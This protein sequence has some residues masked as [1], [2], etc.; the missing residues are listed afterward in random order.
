M[1]TLE[2]NGLIEMFR[3]NPGLA[4]HFLALLFHVDVPAHATARVADSALDQLIPIEFRA[5]LVLELRDAEGKL[6]LAIVLESQRD[7]APR[8]KFSWPVYITVARAERECD[9]VVL[10]IA[11]DAEIAAWAAQTIDLGLGRGTVE[12]FVL[13]PATV[14]VVTDRAVA[15]REIELAILLAMAH[16]NGPKGLRVVQVVFQALAPRPRAQGGGLSDHL[17]PVARACAR[18]SEGDGHGMAG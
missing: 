5:D 13:G 4:P 3:K 11:I 15:N 18:G 9:A 10:V 1:P 7:K 2:H 14:P 8:K 6:V 17:E 16:G 12:P